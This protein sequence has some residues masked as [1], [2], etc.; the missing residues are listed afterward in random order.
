MQA[1]RAPKTEN[2][3]VESLPVE[4]GFASW[5]PLTLGMLLLIAILLRRTYRRYGRHGRRR[6]SSK[7]AQVSSPRPRQTPLR[8]APPEILQWQVEMQEIARDVKAELDTK[9]IA[10]QTL[11]RVAQQEIHQLESAIARAEDQ[12]LDGRLLPRSHQPPQPSHLPG[13]R[14][15]RRDAYRLADLGHSPAAIADFLGTSLGDVD[16][17]LGCRTSQE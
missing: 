3:I 11:V 17:I 4:S 8:D 1:A 5:A 9:M 6:A 12:R 10:L 13:T 16:L 14:Q 7:P 2:P 15:Q